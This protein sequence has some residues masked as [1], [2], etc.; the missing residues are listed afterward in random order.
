MLLTAPQKTGGSLNYKLATDPVL[1]LPIDGNALR[2]FLPA[3]RIDSD[4]RKKQF[5]AQFP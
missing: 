1:V 3:Y 2:A 4:G 5:S